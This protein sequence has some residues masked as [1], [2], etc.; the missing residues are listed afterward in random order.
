MDL[1]V[2]IGVIAVVL[3][4]VGLFLSKRS[5]PKV[6]VAAPVVRPPPP[7]PEAVSEK[8]ASLV[9]MHVY[10]GSQTGTAEGFSKQIFNEAKRHGFRATV[11]DL[12]NFDV[13]TFVAT[14]QPDAGN[15]HPHVAVFVLA[16]YGEGDPTDN[17][18]A[19]TKWIKVRVS[20]VVRAPS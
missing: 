6:D 11:V 20:G 4:V 14:A 15:G 8:D 3:G 17:A 7:Q 2:L 10:Y 19:F 5:G 9:P 16:T 1:Y 13:G 18:I 12:E